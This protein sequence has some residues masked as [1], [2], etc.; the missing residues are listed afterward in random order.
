MT[1]WVQT[2]ETAS[3]VN[4][5]AYDSTALVMDSHKALYSNNN[6]APQHD[7]PTGTMVEQ[8]EANRQTFPRNHCANL[9]HGSV[10]KID[11]FNYT[12]VNQFDNSHNQFVYIHDFPQNKPGGFYFL[13]FSYQT[14]QIT[15]LECLS[16]SVDALQVCDTIWL[17]IHHTISESSIVHTKREAKLAYENYKQDC[18]IKQRYCISYES[19]MNNVIS[20]LIDVQ[21][22]VENNM[23]DTPNKTLTPH[24]LKNRNNVSEVD[25]SHCTHVNAMSDKKCYTHLHKDINYPRKVRGYIAMQPTKFKFIGPDRPPIDTGNS[26]Q[27]LK[28]AKTIRESGVLNYRQVRVSIKSGLNIAAWRRQLYDY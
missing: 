14:G 20:S 27:Y 26:N 17:S 25:L 28:L 11:R 10:H 3:H 13:K 22:N 8:M 15:I 9:Y 2:V 5:T 23:T 12:F 7:S 16:H 1:S 24:L 19:Y 21:Y 18:L 4:L 6:P